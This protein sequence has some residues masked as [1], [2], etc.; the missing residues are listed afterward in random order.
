MDGIIALCDRRTVW[1]EKLR[2]TA[3]EVVERLNDEEEEKLRSKG[4]AA[5]VR[6]PEERLIDDDKKWVQLNIDLAIQAAKIIRQALT[7]E[8]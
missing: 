7:E 2:N 8:V 6:K 1:L 3:Q 4:D 5:H